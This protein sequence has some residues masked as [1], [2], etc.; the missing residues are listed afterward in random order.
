MVDDVRERGDSAVKDYTNKFDK[1][2]LDWV[3]KKIEVC[4]I[5]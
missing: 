3:C 5:S 1:V 4:K 2:D